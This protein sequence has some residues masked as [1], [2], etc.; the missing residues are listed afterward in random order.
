MSKLVL[1][2]GKQLRF[3]VDRAYRERITTEIA[4]ECI[5]CAYETPRALTK[6]ISFKYNTDYVN[7]ATEVT[8][9]N[10]STTLIIRL[11]D[12]SLRSVKGAFI[13]MRYE[14]PINLKEVGLAWGD[15]TDLYALDSP[16]VRCLVKSRYMYEAI[17]RSRE[18]CSDQV[19]KEAF[20]MLV[21]QNRDAMKTAVNNTLLGAGAIASAGGF[22]SKCQSEA[23]ASP[24]ILFPECEW[25]ETYNVVERERD[26]YIDKFGNFPPALGEDPIAVRFDEPIASSACAINTTLLIQPGQYRLSKKT[27]KM[28]GW[29]ANTLEGAQA[30]VPEP[31]DPWRNHVPITNWVEIDPPLDSEGN[32]TQITKNWSSENLGIS[33]LRNVTPGLSPGFDFNVG[34]ALEGLGPALEL[35]D[36]LSVGLYFIGGRFGGPL[37]LAIDCAIEQ[38]LGGNSYIPPGTSSGS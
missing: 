22:L 15:I 25:D 23:K 16:S 5:K 28:K 34:K 8:G 27:V 24:G 31:P 17:K 18:I 30:P 35:L 14:T 9:F 21:N 10:F 11:P 33:N 13:P 4:Q 32:R 7:K 37:F 6:N 3:R 12:G 29:N 20:E 1:S 36:A 26:I 2:F 38:A 19:S